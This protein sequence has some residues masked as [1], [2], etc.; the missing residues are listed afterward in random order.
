MLICVYARRNV[1]F[2]ICIV[3][4]TLFLSVVTLCDA[5]SMLMYAGWKLSFVQMCSFKDHSYGVGSYAHLNCSEGHPDIIENGLAPE[6]AY[7]SDLAYLKKKVTAPPEFTICYNFP[8]YI[9]L[10]E[11]NMYEFFKELHHCGPLSSSG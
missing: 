6:E 9:Y 7:Q 8:S 4:H 11:I 1:D 10:I 2:M 3:M 5:F